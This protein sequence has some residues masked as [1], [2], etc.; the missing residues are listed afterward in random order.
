MSKQRYNYSGVVTE[1]MVISVFVAIQTR[2]DLYVHYV[3]TRNI[4]KMYNAT[5]NLQRT[6][7]SHNNSMIH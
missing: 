2:P 7:I 4:R 1:N 3:S 6:T 5:T